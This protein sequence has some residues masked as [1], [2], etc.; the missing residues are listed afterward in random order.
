MKRFFVALVGLLAL[1]I[2]IRD[3]SGSTAT[4]QAAEPTVAKA[5]LIP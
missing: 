2:F 4:A 1:C 3:F 5:E